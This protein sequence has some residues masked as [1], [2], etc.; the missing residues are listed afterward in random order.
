MSFIMEQAGGKGS[1][2]KERILDIDP[3]A[4]HQ[5]VPLYIGSPEEVDYAE[6][7]VKSE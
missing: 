3:T 2:G 1:T 4:V 5:R 6:S 7:F